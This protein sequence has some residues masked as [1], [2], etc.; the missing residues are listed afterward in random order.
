MNPLV[1]VFHEGW[2]QMGSR[3]S[4]GDIYWRASEHGSS[5]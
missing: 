2:D 3:F 5:G 4:V 1:G